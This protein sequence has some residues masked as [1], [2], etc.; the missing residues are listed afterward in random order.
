[1]QET[2][3]GACR[4]RKREIDRKRESERVRGIGIERETD[5]QTQ[6]WIERLANRHTETM[7]TRPSDL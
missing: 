7:A 4:K 1:M 3:K 5:S 2:E 6:R